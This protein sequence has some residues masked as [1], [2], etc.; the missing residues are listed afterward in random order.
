M[1]DRRF[2][3][4]RVVPRAKAPGVS[5]GPDGTLTVRVAAPA[6]DGRANRAVIEAVAEHL[7]LPRSVVTMVRGRTGRR[8][9][10]QV[11]AS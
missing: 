6:E 11:H 2:V 10:L 7:H 4:V 1:T 3:A 8:K 5:V 9:L